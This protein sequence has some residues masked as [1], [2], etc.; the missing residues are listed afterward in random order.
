MSKEELIWTASLALEKNMTYDELY[1]SDYM[2][3][4]EDQTGDVWE[5][6]TE[7]KEIGLKKF[8]KKYK[9]YKLY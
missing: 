4:N 2:Y 3:D 8:R 5:Y 1:Y 9:N 6:V 7:G